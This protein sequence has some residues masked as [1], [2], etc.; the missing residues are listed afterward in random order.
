MNEPMTEAELVRIENFLSVGAKY[1]EEGSIVALPLVAE[2]RRLRAGRQWTGVDERLPQEFEYVLICAHDDVTMG[3]YEG[4]DWQDYV[5]TGYDCV[6]DSLYGVTHWM[7]IPEP[8]QEPH[9]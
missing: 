9:P 8:P 4:G 1:G 6:P 5:N 3:R 2:V 7:P